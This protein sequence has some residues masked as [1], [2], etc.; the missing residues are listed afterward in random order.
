M[1]KK[2]WKAIRDKYVRELKN[3]NDK[4]EEGLTPRV[5][6]WEHFTTLSFIKAHIRYIIGSKFVAG[7][8]AEVIPYCV[9][10]TQNTQKKTRPSLCECCKM[11][12]Y[13][14]R[15]NSSEMHYDES[16]A[17]PSMDDESLAHS[18]NMSSL[19]VT[20][21]FIIDDGNN[22]MNTSTYEDI[23][24][25]PLSEFIVLK[26]A[27]DF[28]PTKL[29]VDLSTLIEG[30]RVRP[31]LYD[32]SNPLY[33]NSRTRDTAWLEVATECQCSTQLAR[34]K[35]K[36][37]RTKYI[38]ESKTK[39]ASKWHYW[40][41]MHFI[42]DHLNSAVI[43][44][45]SSDNNDVLDVGSSNESELSSKIEQQQQQQQQPLGD[46]IAIDDARLINL[47]KENFI[48]YDR[49]HELYNNLAR[50]DEVWLTLANIM[51]SRGTSPISIEFLC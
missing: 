8:G 30:I 50:K 26:S 49:S 13:T 39:T 34:A 29:D 45:A 19:L 11:F 44:G 28:T 31:L 14:F 48:L 12:E 27:S 4:I 43:R 25:N 37:L 15:L 3:I 40:E 5:P 16:V 2:R 35:W 51:H 1:I 32:R 33:S 17:D 20:P 18:A 36:F 23:D 7:L 41:Q 9:S 46:E 24:N 21:K 6:T 38:N 10:T 47:V 42:K 22:Q